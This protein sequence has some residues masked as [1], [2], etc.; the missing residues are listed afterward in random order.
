MEK[1]K[2]ITNLLQGILFVY[3]AYRIVQLEKRVK[4]IEIMQSLKNRGLVKPFLTA[5]AATIFSGPHKET[6]LEDQLKEALDNE[7]F[8]KAAELKK[9]IEK[10]DL[11][12]GKK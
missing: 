5:L 8:E 4:G 11:E 12:K 9:E 6:S 10:R 1:F 3:M 7:E 2:I